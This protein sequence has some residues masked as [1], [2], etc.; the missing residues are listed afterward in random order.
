[1]HK[2]LAA[3][4]VSLSVIVAT[5]VYGTEQET[6]D[7][8]ARIIRDFRPMPE[9]SI[10]RSVLTH[11]QGLAIITVLKAGFVFSGKV[12]HGVVVARTA[13]GWSGPS[14]VGQGGAGWGL[15]IG[16]EATDF[17]F[18][19]NTD[20][21]VRAFSKGGNITLGADASVAAG[22]VGR[23]AHVAVT[24]T[25]AIY[26]YSWTKGLFAG[27]AVEGAVFGTQKGENTRYY[28]RRVAARE[29]LQ[30]EVRPPP[31]A[32]DLQSALGR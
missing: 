22:P 1:M 20:A 17:V 9:S 31:G 4:F 32:A 7:H 8:C 26:T 23:D 21:A 19:L 29:I 24:P 16:A 27:A 13:T 30:G 3:I 11:S 6:V 14:F 28:R 15:Q 2:K 10:P 18:V 12:G 25:T 5:T